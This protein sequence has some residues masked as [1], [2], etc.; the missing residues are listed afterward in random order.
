MKFIKI[1]ENVLMISL[2][3]YIV[4]NTVF[5]WNKEPINLYEEI[6]DVICQLGFF[7]GLVIYIITLL[8]MYVKSNDENEI[9]GQ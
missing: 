3:F 7:I 6:R 9:D 4:Y 1:G 2:I 5:G 8:N